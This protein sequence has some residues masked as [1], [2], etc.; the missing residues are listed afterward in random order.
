[1]NNIGQ[2]DRGVVVDVDYQN[3][4]FGNETISSS[5]DV[6]IGWN[7]FRDAGAV[8]MRFIYP[9]ALDIYVNQGVK[10]IASY[11]KFIGLDSNGVPLYEQ[12]GES[13]I[14]DYVTITEEGYVQIPE[15]IGIYINQD[16]TW[17]K[18][19]LNDVV[20][21]TKDLGEPKDVRWGNNIT[22]QSYTDKV[23]LSSNDILQY[24]FGR[25]TSAIRHII[26][27]KMPQI[28]HQTNLTN[29]LK[30]HKHLPISLLTNQTKQQMR[31]VYILNCHYY[32]L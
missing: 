27:N 26:Y 3:G 8:G 31:L 18:G 32:L 10:V 16:D 12:I 29:L 15:E 13:E 19:I 4:K 17:Y 7:T 23:E 6:R 1:M 20:N 2:L 21:S 30:N 28:P 25:Y 9:V 11:A 5:N 24:D 14:P 22:P